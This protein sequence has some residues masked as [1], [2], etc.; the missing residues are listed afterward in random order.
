MPDWAWR[1]ARCVEPVDANRALSADASTRRPLAPGRLGAVTAPGFDY[2]DPIQMRPRSLEPS[3]VAFLLAISAASVGAGC[4]TIAPPAPGWLATGPRLAPTL[5]RRIADEGDKGNGQVDHF[6]VL[7]GANT[8]LRHRGNLSMAYQVLIEQGYAPGDIYVL[9]A[10]GD[11]PFVPVAAASNRANVQRLFA[12]LRDIV[13]SHDTLLIYVTG[14]GR[15]VTADNEDHGHR[16]TIGVSTILLNKSE[17]M[18]DWEF[19]HLLDG[20]EPEVGMAFFDQCYGARFSMVARSC[21][22]V[23]ITTADEAETSYGVSFPRAFWTAFRDPRNGA[24]SP[25]VSGA[26]RYAL[27]ADRGTQLGLNRPHLTQR[28]IDPEKLTL[29]GTLRPTPTV[30]S[31]AH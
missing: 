20:I 26:Y 17:E 13:E 9:D 1:L 21:N 2:T 12:H 3:F 18:S 7:I 28:C 15:R 11:S 8:E 29:L 25:S 16:S 4:A 14:H 10:E 22:F 6:A 5:E 30:L 24:R 19:A 27:E 31:A 23:V